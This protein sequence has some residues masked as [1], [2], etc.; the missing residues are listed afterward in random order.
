MT[1]RLITRRRAL[2]TTAAGMAAA[3]APF[4]FARGRQKTPVGM[5]LVLAA[6]VSQSVVEE[7]YK[8]QMD[9]YLEA[10]QSGRLLG[11]IQNLEPPRLA[12]LFLVWSEL[13]HILM[14]WTLLYDKVSVSEFC[15]RFAAQ[16]AVR[17]KL[18]MYTRIDYLMRFCISQFDQEYTGGRRVLDISGDGGNSYAPSSHPGLKKAKE[19]LV[20][21]GVT[22]NGLPILV[23]PPAHIF[24]KQPPEGLDVYY[25]EHVV[26]GVGRFMIP[27]QGFEDFHRA[28]LA[29]LVAEIA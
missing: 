10:F 1:R 15:E 21:S 2:V 14:P 23:L 27:S 8:M 19:A 6:D 24:P 3:T 22:I 18:G 7:R 25:R 29:K 5:Q 16:A 17:P 11:A 28:I 13:Q 9:G 12:V 4:G 20:A 26:G